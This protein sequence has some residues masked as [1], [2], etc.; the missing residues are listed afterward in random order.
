MMGYGEAMNGGEW[1]PGAGFEV[2][3]DSQ[4]FRLALCLSL[5]SER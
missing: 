1:D 2:L 3:K 5:V 4:H